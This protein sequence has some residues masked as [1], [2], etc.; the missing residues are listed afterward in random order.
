M[1]KLIYEYFC[2]VCEKEFEVIQSIKDLPLK[3]C[4][5]CIENGI[6]SPPPKKLISRSTFVL[7]GGSWASSGYK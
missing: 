1:F 5:T 6:K 7:K 4:P 2:A 3:E